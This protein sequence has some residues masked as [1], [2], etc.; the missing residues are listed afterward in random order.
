L[1]LI[2]FSGFGLLAKLGLMST[3]PLWV[4]LKL[5]LWLVLGAAVAAIRRARSFAPALLLALPLLGAAAAYL[6]IH[7]VSM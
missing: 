2:L 1:L 3:V 4:W 5:V 7:R 6:V